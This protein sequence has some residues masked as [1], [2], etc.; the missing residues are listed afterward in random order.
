MVPLD[1]DDRVEICHG[2][3]YNEDHYIFDAEDALRAME[4]G[5]RPLCL[6]GHTHL[7]VV[8]RLHGDTFGGFV[9]E[10]EPTRRSRCR[11]ACVTWSIPAR[12]ASPA[13]V[14]RAP[15]SPSTTRIV[16]TGVAERALSGDA[17][18]AEDSGRRAASEPGQ[19]AGVGWAEL[20]RAERL[21]HAAY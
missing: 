2:S 12:S 1:I 3:P 21:T 19:P 4:A 7:P 8:F 5:E 18:A 11:T 6:F 17:A 15:P 13:R 10:G 20:R 9:P 14:I 16:V